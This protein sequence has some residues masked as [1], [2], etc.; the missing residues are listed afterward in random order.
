MW[1]ILLAEFLGDLRAQK[2]RAGLTIFAIAWGTLAI[3]LMLAEGEGLKRTLVRGTLGAG[4]WMFQIYGG[5]TS[6]PF[7]GLPKGRPIRLTEADLEVITRS[8]PE[9]D[10]VSPSYGRSI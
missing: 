8:I 2:M 1:R 3:M 6:L 10:L 4:Q 5:E 7:E 9:V